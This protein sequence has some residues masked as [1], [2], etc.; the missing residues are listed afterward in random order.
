MVGLK[1]TTTISGSIDVA[2]G[3]ERGCVLCEAKEI[4]LQ[5]GELSVLQSASGAPGSIIITGAVPGG[6]A[7]ALD[8]ATIGG[9]T[10][11][12]DIVLRAAAG[13]FQGDAIEVTGA[14]VQTSGAVNIRAG[15]V[16]SDLTA[17]D[18]VSARIQYVAHAA[19]GP[20]TSGFLPITSKLLSDIGSAGAPSVFIIGSDQH[21]GAIRIDA[22]LDF[23]SGI[24]GFNG[25]DLTLQN[26][27]ANSQGIQINA[28]ITLDT[29]TLALVTS[30]PVTQSAPVHV[31]RLA[32]R[33]FSD[34][35]AFSLDNPGNELVVIAGDPTS[36]RL[37]AKS[38]GSINFVSSGSVDLSP[39]DA[40][41]MNSAT[42]AATAIDMT[43]AFF[44]GSGFHVVALTGDII[45]DP[46]ISTDAGGRI[47]LSMPAGVFINSGHGLLDPNNVG[48]FLVSEQSW[49][50]GNRSEVR[51]GVF[52]N[53]PIPNVYGCVTADCIPNDG[54]KFVYQDRPDA[55]VRIDNA[56]RDLGAPNP[57]FGFTV[58][59]VMS[60][61]GDT[62]S[63]VASGNPTTTAGIF[64]LPGSYAITRGTIASP[65]NYNLVIL[66]GS[67]AVQPT[68]DRVYRPPVDSPAAALTLPQ[69]CTAIAP[70]PVAYSESDEGDAVDRDWSRVKQRLVLS[71]YTGVR[72]KESCGDF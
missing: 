69:V 18:D 26:A 66:D 10:Q 32:L 20:P 62:P 63:V 33:G 48:S 53:G 6:L 38:A 36:G 51:G 31:P 34:Q 29:G 11:T 71:S 40:R 28:P 19:D 16:N 58:I 5:L 57:Q 49:Q 24:A 70:A 21:R 50:V 23:K 60:S 25:T 13:S 30:G 64:A 67:L 54:H 17:N 3:R 59:G 14:T 39:V 27:G 43:G 47:E 12:G 7:I 72:L 46:D 44:G 2:G 55:L 8:H 45:L 52:G 42:N 65:A 68:G 35:A 9:N 15:S 37:A 61:L 4:G 56:I 1:A 41:G 22:A